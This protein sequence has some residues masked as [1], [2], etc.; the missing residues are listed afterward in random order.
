MNFV[1]VAD[2]VDDAA[3]VPNDEF[4]EFRWIGATELERLESPLNVREF[5]FRALAA[6]A[7]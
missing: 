7:K 1:F 3:V 6:R 2:V 4:G 5:G